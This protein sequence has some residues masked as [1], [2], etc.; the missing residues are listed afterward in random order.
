MQNDDFGPRIDE[1]REDEIERAMATAKKKYRVDLSRDDAVKFAKLTSEVGWW[2]MREI[3]LNKTDKIDKKI[4]EEFRNLFKVRFSKEIPLDKS[5]QMIRDFILA[6]VLKEK[7]RIL[8]EI[9]MIVAK[10]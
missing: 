8:D 2:M 5:D 1:P 7:S 9:R 6:S 4:L 10:Y 3:D